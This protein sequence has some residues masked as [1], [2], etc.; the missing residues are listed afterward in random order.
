[1]TQR[2][3]K[4]PHFPSAKG[5]AL[6]GETGYRTTAPIVRSDQPLTLPP[7]GKKELQSPFLKAFSTCST[8]TADETDTL[9]SLPENLS[10]AEAVQLLWEMKMKRRRQASQLPDTVTKLQAEDGSLV[11][12]VGTAHFSESS[13]QD[14]VKTIQ[15]VQPDVVL[16]ELCQYRVSMLKMDERTLLKEAKEINMEKVQQAIKQNGVMSGLMQ[17]LLLKVSAHITEQLGMAPGGEFREAFREEDVEKCKQKDLLE[18]TMSE[19]I[20]EFPDLHRTIVAERDIYLAYMLQQAAKRVEVL[21]LA[22]KM[23]AVVVGV[24]GMGHVPGIESNWNKPL[25]IQEIMR[26]DQ[27]SR[28]AQGIASPV[29]L[30]SSYPGSTDASDSHRALW[31]L[32]FGTALLGS[33]WATRGRYTALLCQASTTLGECF[34]TS[35]TGNLGYSQMQPTFIRIGRTRMTKLARRGVEAEGNRKRKRK[36]GKVFCALFV[37]SALLYHALVGN[38]VKEFP[39]SK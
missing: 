25:N 27:G 18:Q 15:A 4:E 10:D 28:Y 30:D 8:S 3:N 33:V 5:V 11:Y 17:I 38:E 24:V 16:V 13:K 7:R 36:E 31:E 22:E 26:K 39:T 29:A 21:P 14:V 37:L 2:G 32:E 1:M 23:P 34:Q 35:L 6:Y 20:G 9:P 12:L 19:M